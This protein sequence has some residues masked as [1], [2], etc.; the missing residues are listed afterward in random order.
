MSKDFADFIT[1]MRQ[2]NLTLRANSGAWI[3]H[4][5]IANIVVS[6]NAPQGTVFTVTLPLVLSPLIREVVPP[7]RALPPRTRLC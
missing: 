5:V 1:T 4:G 2:A 7:S 3:A 6:A